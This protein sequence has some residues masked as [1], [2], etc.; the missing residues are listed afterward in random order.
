MKILNK[1]AQMIE[2][3][4]NKRLLGA[5]KAIGKKYAVMLNEIRQ[6]LAGIYERFEVGG[7]LT[8]AEMAKYS[9][10]QSF[11]KWID[12]L[13][14]THYKSLTDVIYDV[15]GES[16][17]YGY[18]MTAWAVEVETL[19]RL[20]YSTVAAPV[21]KAMIENPI[22]GLTLPSRLAKQRSAVVWSI[23][24]EIT[25]GL[26]EGETY[27]TMAKRVKK[28]LE[29][30]AAKSMR[31]VRTEAHRASE[32]GKLNSAEHANKNGVIMVKEWNSSQDERVRQ[33]TKAD[34]T[35]LDGKKIPVDQSFKQGDGEGKGPGQ[36][37]S[38]YHDINCRCFLSYS[39]EQIE[40]VDAKELEGMVFDTWKE[41]RL[42]KA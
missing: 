41:Q 18:Y 2:K 42:K 22:A 32:T 20:A 29:I 6:Q 23:Q 33:T 36:M 4:L 5:E 12:T 27:S 17:L 39:V 34:H 13:L 11:Y 30:D 7:Q 15:L 9:R 14:G 25:Q 40:K 16:Y 21:I 19:S 35:K 38:K 10:L 28:S 24:Q 8:Y 1:T 31:I 37:N 3:A 26:V